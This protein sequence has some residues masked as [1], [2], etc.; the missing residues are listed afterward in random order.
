MVRLLD[1][2]GVVLAA[3]GPALNNTLS[4]SLPLGSRKPHRTSPRNTAR[5][6]SN[7]RT[8]PAAND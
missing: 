4:F 8:N 6:R 3:K 5:R 2:W 7:S 1:A